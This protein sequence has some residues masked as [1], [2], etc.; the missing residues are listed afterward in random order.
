MK[1]SHSFYSLGL[2]V[3]L[4]SP[5]FVVA[6]VISSDTSKKIPTEINWQACNL[7]ENP[8]L[9]CAQYPVPLNYKNTKKNA[10][11]IHIALIKL[12]A[13]NPAKKRLGSLFLN[14]GGPGGSGVDLVRYVGQYLFNQDIRDQYDLIGFDPRGIHLSEPVTCG[15]TV[16]DI[17]NIIPTTPFP[18]NAQEEA[19]KIQSDKLISAV[20]EKNGNDV[21]DQMTTANVARDLDL[22]RQA[23]GDELLNYVGYSYGSYLGVTYANLFPQKVGR[24]VVDGVID[25]IAWA[26]GEKW[27]GWFVPVT[28]RLESDKNS[29]ATL[30]EFFKFCDLAGPASCSLAGNSAMRFDQVAQGLKA[31]PLTIFLPDGTSVELTYSLLIANSLNAMYNS[32]SWSNLANFVAFIEWQLSSEII[33]QQFSRLHQ[34]LGIDVASIPVDNSLLG[35]SAVLCSDSDN[36]VQEEFWPL[37]AAT[38]EQQNGYFGRLWT[39]NSSICAHWTG[40][41]K[42]RFT[43]PFNK[44]TKNPV[45]IASTLFDPATPYSG[46]Q[47][48]A[49]LLPNSRLI[50]FAGWGHT[51]PGLSRCADNIVHEYLLSGA[52]PET[53]TLCQQDL[54]PFYLPEN[55]ST[56]SDENLMATKKSLQQP[57]QD[58]DSTKVRKAIIRSNLHRLN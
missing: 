58:S 3:A 16:E 1:M 23:V 57:D 18:I 7:L 2:C 12:P 32:S 52:L 46:A 44:K 37:W 30:N 54:M 27:S 56:L 35:F 5:L 26:T 48:V 43:G 41:K 55:S 33:G 17:G 36:P 49:R 34:D 28:T 15:L 11:F 19:Q 13:N 14:P 9:L 24:L 29:M 39:W 8:N 53:N 40:S 22:L 6:D 45:L 4:F 21:I 50:T 51:T 25:P 20:C 10:K 47:K 42:S 38:S 31:K